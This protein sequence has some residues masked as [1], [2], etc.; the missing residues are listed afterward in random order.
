MLWNPI[1]LAYTRLRAIYEYLAPAGKPSLPS[2]GSQS[3]F[4]RP[5]PLKCPT[6]LSKRMGVD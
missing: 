4:P 3:A 2:S 1:P 5:F 6:I